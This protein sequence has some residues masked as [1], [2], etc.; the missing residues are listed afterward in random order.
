M[1]D[2]ILDPTLLAEQGAASA[3]PVVKRED[4]AGGAGAGAEAPADVTTN[5][6]GRMK[7]TVASEDGLKRKTHAN[8]APTTDASTMYWVPSFVVHQTDK[9]LIGRRIRVRGSLSCGCFVCV[10]QAVLS[11]VLGWRKCVFRS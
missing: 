4:L 3:E 9:S 8:D 1:E 10:I 7:P 5:T 11:D 2:S 6:G